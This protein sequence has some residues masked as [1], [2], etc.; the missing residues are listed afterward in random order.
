[1]SP[2]GEITI[3]PPVI[4]TRNASLAAAIYDPSTIQYL[5]PFHVT[6]I[7]TGD[8]R[9][10]RPGPSQQARGRSRRIHS[11]SMAAAIDAPSG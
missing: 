6:V 9:Y 1:M 8:D 3:V 2:T 10:S 4:S 5:T 11:G 7:A